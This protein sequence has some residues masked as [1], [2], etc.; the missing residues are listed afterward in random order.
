LEDYEGG[1]ERAV[2][3]TS[4]KSRSPVLGTGIKG[5]GVGG[6]AETRSESPQQENAPCRTNWSLKYENIGKAQH[7]REVKERLKKG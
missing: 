5:G 2:S 7:G 1:K 3:H 6:C 4:E